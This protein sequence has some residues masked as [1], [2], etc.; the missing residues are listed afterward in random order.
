ML[1]SNF[2]V[3]YVHLP[4]TALRELRVIHLHGNT[5]SCSLLTL[6]VSSNIPII[7]PNMVCGSCFITD[8]ILFCAKYTAFT[9]V[10]NVIV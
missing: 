9:L 6:F 8:W 3:N 2:C 5:V 10:F 1:R 4:C 7:V